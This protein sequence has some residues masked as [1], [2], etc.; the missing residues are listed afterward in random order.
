MNLPRHSD[1]VYG[2]LVFGIA[3]YGQNIKPLD[4]ILPGLVSQ[5]LD[6]NRA[7]LFI[8]GKYTADPKTCTWFEAK[9][10]LEVI[11]S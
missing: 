6:Q 7:G 10:R 1:S 5:L 11:V 4:T 2:R 9:G 8:I 3:F